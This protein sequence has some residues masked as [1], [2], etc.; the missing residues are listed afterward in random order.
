MKAISWASAS[1]APAAT[2]LRIG[3]HSSFNGA[4]AAHRGAAMHPVSNRAARAARGRATE[5][6]DDGR[7][8]DF[9][10]RGG[11]GG[12]SGLCAG[13]SGFAAGVP[14]APG[15]GEQLVGIAHLHRM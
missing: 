15:G 4:S 11:G 6:R 3:S 2:A 10:A 12:P 9:L 8:M 1:G 7:C 5:G 14:V 13:G